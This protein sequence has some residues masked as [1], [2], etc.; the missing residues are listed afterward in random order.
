M[1]N[2]IRYWFNIWTIVNDT[3]VRFALIKHLK[4]KVS[5]DKY[6][7]FVTNFQ[8]SIKISLKKLYQKHYLSDLL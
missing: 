6:L 7:T 5:P 2:R 8:E 1:V 3:F 4:L